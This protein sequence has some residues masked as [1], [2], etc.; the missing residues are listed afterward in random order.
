MKDCF[1]ICTAVLWRS[2]DHGEQ[3]RHLSFLAIITLHLP[4]LSV[5]QTVNLLNR[6][7]RKGM[8]NYYDDLDFKNIM[9]FV[10]KKVGPPPPPPLPHPYDRALNSAHYTL[11]TYYWESLPKAERFLH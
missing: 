9:D 3:Q 6:N 7:I 2:L 1:L 11:I 5:F 8:V 4:G 10:Q